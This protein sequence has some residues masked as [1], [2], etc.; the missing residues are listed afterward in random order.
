MTAMPWKNPA[1]SCPSGLRMVYPT[2]RGV[3]GAAYLS[4]SGP[5]FNP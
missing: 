3:A 1:E 4:F 5:R 2:R